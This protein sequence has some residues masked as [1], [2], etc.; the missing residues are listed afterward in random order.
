MR[1]VSYSA[2]RAARAGRRFWDTVE[3]DFC[4]SELWFPDGSNAFQNAWL[5][6]TVNYS[7]TFRPA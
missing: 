5:T 6:I 1:V 2:L 7:L 3:T 4:S